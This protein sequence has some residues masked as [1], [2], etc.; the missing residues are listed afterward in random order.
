MGSKLFV[1]NSLI[2]MYEKCGSVED[3]Q[4]VFD[5][6]PVWDVVS[7][8]AIIVG[9]FVHGFGKEALDL[10]EKMKSLNMKPNHIT[11]IWVLSACHHAGF[12]DEG[13][14]YF[15]LMNEYY[16]VTPAIEHYYCMVY[17]FGHV[18]HLYEAYNLIT[19]MP[20]KPNATVWASLLDSCRI[21]SN[22][23]LGE[24]VA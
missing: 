3:A 20:V 9:K 22:I 23:E 2:V 1:E 4:Y 19:N 18:G 11:I 7:W 24:R 8:N 17:L 5:N 12:V 10:F 21:C 16:N 15:D 6:M 13:W 14:K